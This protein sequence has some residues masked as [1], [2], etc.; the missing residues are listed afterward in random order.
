MPSNRLATTVEIEMP[1]GKPH[2]IRKIYQTSGNVAGVAFRRTDFKRVQELQEDEYRDEYRIDRPGVYVLWGN[3]ERH[4][5]HSIYIGQS[6]NVLN[7]LTNHRSGTD[8]DYWS[9]TCVFTSN[10]DVFT[11]THARAVEAELIAIAKRADT[12]HVE[13]TQ[14]AKQP[15]MRS[16]R[17]RTIANQFL[18]E[19]L[20]CIPFLG[21]D[22]FEEVDGKELTSSDQNKPDGSSDKEP[23]DSEPGSDRSEPIEPTVAGPNVQ[24]D[25]SIKS[26]GIEARGVWDGHKLTVKAGSQAVR[27]ETPSTL[28]PKFRYITDLRSKLLVDGVL[29]VVGNVLVFE[30]DWQFNTPS[31]ASSTVLGSP[32]SGNAVWK[33]NQNRPLGKLQAPTLPDDA[34]TT[35]KP[36]LTIEKP[37]DEAESD[38]GTV[39][40][41]ILCIASKGI[42]ASGYQSGDQFVVRA[43]SEVVKVLT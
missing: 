10:S 35:I 13:N 20:L 27:H 33:D 15:T 37:D 4:G 21:A 17:D 14:V 25:L 39:E 19:L 22:F 28:Q 40:P 7:R 12:C 26:K 30:T 42:K 29:K 43:E 1:D 9:N 2:G 32:S 8:K 3:P 18:Q 38:S 31:S 5:P 6:D 23:D 11:G 24:I 16:A 34:E 36:S 41:E